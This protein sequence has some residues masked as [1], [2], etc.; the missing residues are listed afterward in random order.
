M[1]NETV[2]SNSACQSIMMLLEGMKKEE[3]NE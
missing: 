1:I 3:I 2:D